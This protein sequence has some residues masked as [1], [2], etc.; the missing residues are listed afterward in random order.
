[1]LA[2]LVLP[3]D[4]APPVVAPD[5]P[6]AGS[7]LGQHYRRCYG[8]G[9]AAPSGLRMRFTVGEGV[10]VISEFVVTDEHEGAAGLAH[11]G[12]LSAALDETQA[13]LLWVLRK[14]A[15][16]ARLETEYLAPVPVG[17]IVR[18][19]ATCLGVADRKIFTAAEGWLVGRSGPAAA[20]LDLT[21]R[22][23]DLAVGSAERVLALRSAA[24][25]VAVPVE[26]FTAFGRPDL[27]AASM[28]RGV[29]Q[30]PSEAGQPHVEVNP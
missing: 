7:A 1:M 20:T 24:L 8:C 17:S 16:T 3:D 6:P 10:Q 11:G 5:A 13:T 28:N 26:H 23:M 14:P 25:F 15:V 4:L 12:L 19:E 29:A 2:P 18:I 30:A 22:A 9:D 27:V 21:G